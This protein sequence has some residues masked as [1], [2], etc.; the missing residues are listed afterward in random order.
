MLAIAAVI[1]AGATFFIYS[2]YAVV[3]VKTVE[4]HVIVDNYVGINVGTD[5][6][7]FGTVMP[8]GEAE[9]GIIITN[10]YNEGLNVRVQVLGGLKGWLVP[11]EKSFYMENRTRKLGFT[12]MV[13]EDAEIGNY[14]GE[15]RVYFLRK[16]FG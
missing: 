7:Y 10:N 14:T 1:A 12:L 15:V 6:L 4:A 2:M 16:P 3:D 13:P 9:R 11:E 5:K 8:G